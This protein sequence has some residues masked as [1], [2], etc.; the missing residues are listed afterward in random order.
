VT[1][2]EFLA[3]GLAALLLHA[4]VYLVGLRQVLRTEFAIFAYHLFPSLLLFTWG[5]AFAVSD[6]SDDRIAAA[7]ALTGLNGIY[8]LTFLELW[9]LSQISYSRE[10]LVKAKTGN[11]RPA[12]SHADDLSRLGDEKR[13]ARLESLRDM[14]LLAATQGGWKLDKRGRMVSALLQLLLWLPNL[15]S[16]G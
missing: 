8:S 9:T 13:T 3:Y 4:S 14:G 1:V 15:R 2:N 11:L 12:S 7:V 16:R 10:V 6:L 5:V